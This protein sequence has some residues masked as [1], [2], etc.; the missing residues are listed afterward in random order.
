MALHQPTSDCAGSAVGPAIHTGYQIPWQ[1]RVL[2]SINGDT[3]GKT[4]FS[5]IDG[6]GFF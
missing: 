2:I 6:G 3:N 1:D 5:E 4:S